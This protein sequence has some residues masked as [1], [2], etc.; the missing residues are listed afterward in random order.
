M[1]EALTG[2][3]GLFDPAMMTGKNAKIGAGMNAGFTALAEI[4]HNKAYKGAQEAGEAMVNQQ[5]STTA[6]LNKIAKS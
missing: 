2:E 1:Q 6:Q 3:M 4:Q 5:K